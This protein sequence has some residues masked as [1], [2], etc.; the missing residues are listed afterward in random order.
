M[1]FFTLLASID[2]QM[3]AY[4]FAIDIAEILQ[5]LLILGLY[6]SVLFEIFQ[7]CTN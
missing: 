2:L 5:S 3:I 7:F 6:E 1:Y 4:L